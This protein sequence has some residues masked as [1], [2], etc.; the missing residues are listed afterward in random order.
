MEPCPPQLHHHK[1]Y[2]HCGIDQVV[3]EVEVMVVGVKFVGDAH[4]DEDGG[5]ALEVFGVEEA[6]L[7]SDVEGYVGDA[8]SDHRHHHQGDGEFDELE[9]EAGSFPIKLKVHPAEAALDRGFLI[10]CITAVAYFWVLDG[11]SHHMG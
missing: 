6:P 5:G 11:L 10:R 7:P 2:Q 3:L 9:V 1:H 8:T 4:G